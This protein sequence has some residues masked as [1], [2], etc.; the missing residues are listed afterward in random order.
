MSTKDK[1]I[2]TRRPAKAD[3]ERLWQAVVARDGSFDG[4]FYY[5]VAT[6]GVYCRPSCASRL[7]R[8]ENV[9][10]H[11]TRADAEATGFRPCKRC[12]P[13]EPG[14]DQ[15]HRDKVAAACRMI[16][17]ADE[18]P[19]LEAL[20]RA[21]GLSRHYFHRIFKVVAGVTP[22]AYASAHRRKRLR[23]ILPASRT[24]TEAI[25]EAGFNSG[26]RFY[27]QGNE[28]IG[29][30]PTAFRTG[31]ANVEM[32][33]AVSKCALGFVL[34]AATGKGIAAILLGDDP[35][36][37]TRDLEMRFP[38]A[39]LVGAD[40]A[41]DRVVAE[42]AALADTPGRAFDLPLDIRGTAFQQ[43]VW[44]ALRAIP[45]GTT[46][47]YAEIAER[48]G[49][50]EAVRAVAGAC[51]ANAIAI[52]IPCHRVV[53]RDGVLSGYRWGVERKRALLAREKKR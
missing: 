35:A 46:A 28:I 6:T 31:G 42:V 22:K 44:E 39:T 5:S 50:P 9:R 2:A 45:A 29:M 12:R 52:A 13:N 37:L 30:T 7:A 25:H 14:P 34:V 16:E 33:L 8:R 36:Q 1:A 24:V 38:K 4:T 18:P 19:S 51:A 26:G 41:F 43:R 11:A 21:N 49:Q 32:R 23:E 27:A 53:R 40:E 48:I 3:D 15:I 47:T 17:E 10:F 20:A